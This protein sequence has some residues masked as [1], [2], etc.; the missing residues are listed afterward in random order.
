MCSPTP[1]P[2]VRGDEPRRRRG[3][4]QRDPEHVAAGSGDR[5]SGRAA[6]LL[7]APGRRDPGEP[8]WDD[9]GVHG[10]EPGDGRPAAAVHWRVVGLSFLLLLVTFRSVVVALKAG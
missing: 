2:S 10:P 4:A 5:G 1:R 3:G 8:R 9:R 7:G 6:A